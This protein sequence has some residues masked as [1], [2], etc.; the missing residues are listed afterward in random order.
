MR[1]FRLRPYQKKAVAAVVSRYQEQNQ[2]RMLLY[3]PTG[4]GKTVIA[5]HIIKAL[6]ASKAFGKVL[7][8]AHRREIIDQT[9]RTIRRHLPGLGVQIEQGKRTVKAQGAITLAS[10]QSLVRRKE[11]YDPKDYAL[12]ICD[13]C[14]RALAPSWGEVIDYFHIQADQ[15]TLLL[16]M[17]ATPQRT[18]GKSALDIFGRTAFEIS[19]ADLED[20]GYLVP[21][22]YFT[23]RGNLNLDKVRMSAGDFQVGALSRVMNTAANRALTLKAWMEQGEGKKTIAFCAGVDHALDLASDF[24]ALGI[25]A[26]KIDGKSK[27]RGDILKRFT[28][29][30]IQ[31]L[32]NYGVLTEGFDDPSVECI[33]MA[34]PTTSPLV[35][36]QCI[37]RGLRTSPGKHACIV[38]DIVDRSAH[39]LQYGATQM[40]GLSKGWRSRGSDPFRQARSFAGIKVTSPDA[41][42]RLRDAATM[43]EVQSI[44]MSLPPEVVTAGLDGEPVLHYEAREG[45]CSASEARTSTREILKQVGAGGTRLHVDET[46]LRITFRSPETENERFAYL[47]WHIQRVACRTVI[48]DPPKRKGGAVRPRTLLRSILPDGCQI[49]NLSADAQNDTISASIAGLTPDEIQD[50]QADFEE[51]YGMRLDLKGQMSLF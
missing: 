24:S 42:L 46:T 23:I 13:E 21:M 50:I 45:E 38:I 9:A 16:G 32:T 49:R 4:A 20:L 14:H 11:K 8:V 44:L 2:R 47:K 48:F 36:T 39:P 37:G 18:D 43:E 10:V 33:L 5:T 15:E 51:E 3:L 25:R 22:R 27:N 1:P 19:R 30:N 41:F 17:T 31:V 40:A 35:Y 7:F 29:G 34:R 28:D 6:R 12:I 26:E